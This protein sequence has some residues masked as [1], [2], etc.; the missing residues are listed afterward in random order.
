MAGN[1][2][3]DVQK[4]FKGTGNQ[5]GYEFIE[6]KFYPFKE[7]KS[8]WH[9]N[10]WKVTFRISDYMSGCGD[11]VLTDYAEALF[12]IRYTEHEDMEELVDRMQRQ[13]Q[14]ELRVETIEPVFH[15]GESPYLDLLLHIAE[16]TKVGFEHGASDARFLSERGIK[17]IVWGA[18]GDQTQHSETEH[19]TIESVYGLY[20]MLDAFMKRTGEV[21]L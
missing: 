9:R 17:G 8:T 16:D 18:E 15:G 5:H 19:V 10:R 7:L 1:G 6:A 14:G 11:D 12:D 21:N 3:Q 20:R 13:I 2:N 4:I